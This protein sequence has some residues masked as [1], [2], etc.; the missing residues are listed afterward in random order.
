MNRRKFVDTTMRA[1]VALMASIRPTT[2]QQKPGLK[3]IVFSK[4]LKDQS[5]GELIESLQAV[6]ADGVDLAVRPG[7]PVNPLNVAEALQPAAELIRAAELDIPMVTAP[8]DLTNISANYVVPLFRACGEAGIEL[9][10]LGYWRAPTDNYWAAVDRMKEDIEGFAKLGERYG[11]K[12]CLHTHS[13]MNMGLNAAALMH[14]LRHFDP[15]RIGAYIDVGHLAICGEPPALGFAMAAEW[16]S[17]VG[18][19]DMERTKTDKGLH[20]RTVPVGEGF[21]DWK[22]TI[23][24]LVK[25]EFAGPLTF[26]AE[27]ETD[28][29][30]HLLEGVRAEIAFVRQLEDT[31]RQATHP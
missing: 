16:L 28:S 2:R 14:V 29:M 21:V 10:K 20:T 25:H 15:L 13:G 23:D 7:Y 6:E 17:V 22:A 18:I 30:A 8:T 27:F 4:H 26:H 3:Y 5:I 19:K 24:W 31:A 12:P 1:S 11:V 9:L